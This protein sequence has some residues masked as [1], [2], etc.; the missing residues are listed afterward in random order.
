MNY[1]KKELKL[2]I[3]QENDLKSIKRKPFF[4]KP[5]NMLNPKDKDYFQEMLQR[6]YYKK[7]NILNVNKEMNEETK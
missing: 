1:W 3:Q 2:K 4:S 6:K 7:T 5:K